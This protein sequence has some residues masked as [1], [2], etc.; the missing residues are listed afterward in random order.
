MK[1]KSGNPNGAKSM[2][3]RRNYDEKYQFNATS[4][5]SSTVGHLLSVTAEVFLI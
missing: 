4:F 3:S 5:Q 1:I 2:D